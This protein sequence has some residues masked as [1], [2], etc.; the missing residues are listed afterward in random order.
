M[1]VK[2]I[3]GVTGKDAATVSRWIE[4]VSCKMQEV[5]CKVQEAKRTK[6]PADYTL[7]ETCSI[8]EAGMGKQAAD[9]YRANAIHSETEKKK[10]VR[11]SAAYIREVRLTLGKEAAA[12]LLLGEQ[13]EEKR[14]LA[15][16]EPV[17]PEQVRK[18][19][20]AVARAA[21]IRYE[22]EKTDRQKNMTL[23]DDDGGAS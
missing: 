23:F 9:V 15:L 20:Y 14:T 7:A 12:K 21:L 4:K 5:S 2:E 16:P 6:K 17:L 22:R 8:I 10:V 13:A 19:V 1:T 11:Y 18:Q 3:A